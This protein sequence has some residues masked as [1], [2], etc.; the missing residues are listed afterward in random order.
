M[1]STLNIWYNSLLNTAASSISH[2]GRWKMQPRDV[3]LV[4][5]FALELIKTL[6]S[7]NLIVISEVYF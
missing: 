4:L 2:S 1:L 5:V 7:F 6:V 3:C